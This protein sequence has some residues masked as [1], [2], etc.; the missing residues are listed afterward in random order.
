MPHTL[1]C[2]RYKLK[3]KWRPPMCELCGKAVCAELGLCI[4]MLMYVNNVSRIKMKQ[5]LTLI[6]KTKKDLVVLKL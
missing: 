1:P 5:S 4:N 3:H 6:C 2:D